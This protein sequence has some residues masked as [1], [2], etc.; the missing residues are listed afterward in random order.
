MTKDRTARE[1]G[2][3]ER[4]SNIHRLKQELAKTQ[5]KAAARS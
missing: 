1:G 4:L 2:L 3:R 5:D